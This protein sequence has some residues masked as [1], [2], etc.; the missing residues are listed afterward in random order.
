M[1]DPDLIR[2]EGYPPR[3][4]GNPGIITSIPHTIQEY[5]TTEGQAQVQ[6]YPP[7][8]REL[9]WVDTV[10]IGCYM[11]KFSP[12][13]VLTKRLSPMT[14]LQRRKRLP[15]IQSTNWDEIEATIR[16]DR[17]DCNRF[18]EYH[19]GC[20]LSQHV[21]LHLEEKR[22]QRTEEHKSAV[23]VSGNIDVLLITVTDVEAR[24]VLDLVRERFGHECKPHFGEIQ[25][26]YDLGTIGGARIY[27]ARSEVS[28]GGPSGS[29]VTISEAINEISPLAVI[30]VGIA[31]GVDEEKQAIGD[32]L[33]SERLLDYDLQR[34]GTGP[35]GEMRIIPR[36]DRPSA[37]PRLLSRFRD[38]A[39]YWEEA[40]IRFGL[41]LSGLK[42]VDNVD[43]RDQLRTLEPEAIGGEMEGAG[44]YAAAYRRKTDWILAKAICDWADGQKHV[45]KD[46]RQETAARNAASFVIHVIERGGLVEGRP[47]SDPARTTDPSTT[48]RDELE[49]MVSL[50]TWNGHYLRA[51]GGG[52]GRVD[53]KGNEIGEW[54]TFDLIELGDNEIALRA[55]NGDYVYAEGGGGHGLFAN[56]K[57]RSRWETFELVEL[58]DKVALRTYTGQYVCAENGGGREL[59]AN[60]DERCEWETFRLIRHSTA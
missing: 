48:L 13:S 50:Q 12:I 7:E 20:T 51:E 52:G 18:F 14:N 54:E 32:V 28:S 5:Y 31:F 29:N 41:V 11:Q 38:G 30:L 57:H 40:K 16:E 35:E 53:A 37:S 26:Y 2:P 15:L 25:T 8:I 1:F 60:R 58:D 39:L 19:P 6:P 46:Q 55:Q 34:I 33:V 47:T 17:Q 22:G 36:G 9:T 3:L 44:L 49:S 43:Y 27:M 59:I 45:D 56:R 42:L 21:E 10:A 24:A 23:T 4:D